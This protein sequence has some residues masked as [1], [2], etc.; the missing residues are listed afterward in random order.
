MIYYSSPLLNELSESTSVDHISSSFFNSVKNVESCFDYEILIQ[1]SQELFKNSNQL[2]NFIKLNSNDNLQKIYISRFCLTVDDFFKLQEFVAPIHSEHS[3]PLIPCPDKYI[4]FLFENTKKKFITK[5]YG[6][7]VNLFHNL[8]KKSENISS[9]NFSEIKDILH[10]VL[11][12]DYQIF[13]C[14]GSY[15]QN[16]HH[17]VSFCKH[18]I[19]FNIAKNFLKNPTSDNA[20]FLLDCMEFISFEKN[21]L[22]EYQEFD[23]LVKLFDQK[24][25]NLL[26]LSE[27]PKKENF[28]TNAFFFKHPIINSQQPFR[29]K[30]VNDIHFLKYSNL[31]IFNDKLIYFNHFFKEQ[32]T[33]EKFINNT[34]NK[35]NINSRNHDEDGVQFLKDFM[36]KQEKICFHFELN[37]KINSSNKNNKKIKI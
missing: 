33:L 32:D 29:Y 15:M 19:S 2:K 26:A 4:S 5:N 8:A 6:D 27:H 28:I 3:H 34:I 36:L 22:P 14:Y 18:Y 13:H 16:F 7:T 21:A 12:E 20:N 31:S 30:G 10:F 1:Y 17:Y 9:L 24:H 25:W 37:H 11:L 35:K 23:L